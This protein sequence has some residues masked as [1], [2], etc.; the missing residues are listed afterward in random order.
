MTV[1]LLEASQGRAKPEARWHAYLGIDTQQV[2]PRSLAI[3]GVREGRGRWEK[4]GRQGHR[5]ESTNPQK[6]SRQRM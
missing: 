5:K 3:I 6:S 4:Q 2:L 1:V